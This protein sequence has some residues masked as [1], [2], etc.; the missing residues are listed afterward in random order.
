MGVN[1]CGCIERNKK[2]HDPKKSDDSEK[3][4]NELFSRM[5]EVPAKKA[6]TMYQ[7]IK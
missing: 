6:L 1:Y 3:P 4:L 5:E 7:A 2:P